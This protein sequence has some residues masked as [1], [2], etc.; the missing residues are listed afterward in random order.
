MRRL[1]G[2]LSR[3]I[4]TLPI[5][6]FLAFLRFYPLYPSHLFRMRS[7]AP[8]L[9]AGFKVVLSAMDFKVP[10]LEISNVNGL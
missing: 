2:T 4:D 10:V 5:L 1:D 6:F 3:E 7:I 8:P 9:H